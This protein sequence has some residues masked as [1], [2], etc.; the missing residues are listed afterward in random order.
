MIWDNMMLRHHNEI[1]D[2]VFFPHHRSPVGKDSGCH[3]I[4]RLCCSDLNVDMGNLNPLQCRVLLSSVLPSYPSTH[5][6][7]VKSCFGR[8]Q[9]SGITYE[10]CVL[11]SESPQKE[12]ISWLLRLRKAMKKII[13]FFRISQ[14]KNPKFPWKFSTSRSG[15]T[16]HNRRRWYVYIVEE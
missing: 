12:P 2:K 10:L 7:R 11:L 4:H 13:D 8:V 3:N 14:D 15:K 9:N 16:Q 5:P 1:H 6:R